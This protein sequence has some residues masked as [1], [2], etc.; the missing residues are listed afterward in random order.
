MTRLLCNYLMQ[1][2][3]SL[4][5]WLNIPVTVEKTEWATTIIAFLGILMDGERLLLSIPMEKQ[6]KALRLLNEITEKNKITV[7]QL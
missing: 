3:L 5:H 1:E 4:C 6:E 7:K 2:F